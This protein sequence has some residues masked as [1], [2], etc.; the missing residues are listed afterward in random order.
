MKLKVSGSQSSLIKRNL[1]PLCLDVRAASQRHVRGTAA[2]V[3]A[4]KSLPAIHVAK[5]GTIP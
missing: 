4:G 2:V 5:K 3:V 1:R